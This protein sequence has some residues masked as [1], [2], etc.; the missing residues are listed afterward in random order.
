[1]SLKKLAQRVFT[2]WNDATLSMLLY[3]RRKGVLVGKDEQG[4]AYY[5][6]HDDSHRWVIYNGYAEASRIP[7]G[8]HAW[9]HRRSDVAPSESDYRPHPWEKPWRPNPTGSAQAEF[10]PGSLYLEHPARMGRPAWRAWQPKEAD[11]G[12]QQP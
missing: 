11:K 1:M 8:W 12:A 6:T 9:I 10:P 7:P 3:T 5:R 2:W 4:N